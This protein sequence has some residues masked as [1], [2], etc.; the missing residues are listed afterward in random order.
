V[1]LSAS[2][3]VEETGGNQVSARWPCRIPRSGVR[4]RG[5]WR[6]WSASSKSF[7]NTCAQTTIGANACNGLCADPCTLLSYKSHSVPAA[8]HVL[9]SSGTAVRP[10]TT[11]TRPTHSHLVM[12]CSHKP[13]AGSVSQWYAAP[14]TLTEMSAWLTAPVWVVKIPDID[15][16]RYP[17]RIR[18]NGF[19]PVGR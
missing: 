13:H 14:A 8:F 7:G 10:P 2:E 16:V 11:V 5:R 17:H 6:I 1:Y 18:C 12:Y 9:H 15:L 4:S 19:H 3:R